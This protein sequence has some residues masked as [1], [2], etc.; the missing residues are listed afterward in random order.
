MSR[1]LEGTPGR[2]LHAEG[3]VPGFGG[4]APLVRSG[5]TWRVRTGVAWK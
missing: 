3:C 2:Q 4:L 5:F 1:G